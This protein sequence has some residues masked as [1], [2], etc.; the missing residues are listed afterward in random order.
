[1][2]SDWLGC[3]HWCVEGAEITRDDERGARSSVVQSLVFNNRRQLFITVDHHVADYCAATAQGIV[4]YTLS[5]IINRRRWAQVSSC[6]VRVKA[7]KII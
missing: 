1:M 5:L 7:H 4:L 6:N 2:S 3:D